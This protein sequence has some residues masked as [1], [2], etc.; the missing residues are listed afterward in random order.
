M[1]VLTV[2]LSMKGETIAPGMKIVNLEKGYTNIAAEY[3]HEVTGGDLFEIRPVREYNPNHMKMIY[4]AKEEFDANARPAIQ[5]YPESVEGYDMIFLCFPNWWATMPM[6]V[7]TFLDHFDW[8]GKTIVPL[9]TSGGSGFANALA[10]LARVCPAAKI[11]S[12]LEVLGHEAEASKKAIQDWA[13]KTVQEEELKRETFEFESF[14]NRT[15]MD[16]MNAVL[17]IAEEKYHRPVRIRV[18]CDGVIVAQYVDGGLAGT[19]WLDRKEN[20]VKATGRPTVELYWH[21]EEHPDLAADDTQAPFGGGLPYVISGEN[22]GAFI[23]S[24]LRHREDHDLA[25]AALKKI[26]EKKGNS[27]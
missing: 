12:G 24:G 20:T 18:T 11:L 14:E 13:W 17:E 2:F 19:E 1:N 22:R 16:F 4:E 8:T 23:V 6:P 26:R 21:P 5:E 15:A 10:D 9:V 7:F 25:M 3:I 27:K